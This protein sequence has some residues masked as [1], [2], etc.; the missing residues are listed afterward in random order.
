MENIKR[1]LIVLAILFGVS[2]LDGFFGW[3]IMDTGFGALVGL[4]ELVCLIWLFV[5]AFKKN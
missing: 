5:L 1:V 4:A 3:G 2:F